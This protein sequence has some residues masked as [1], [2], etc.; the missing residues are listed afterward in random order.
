MSDAISQPSA[1]RR[2]LGRRDL[3]WQFTVR[4]IE[5]KHRGSYLGMLWSVLN[6]LLM[7]GL[8]T[9]MFGVIFGGQFHALPDETKLDYA[10]GLFLGLIFFNVLAETAAMAPILIVTNPNL[11]K[12]VV[13][14]LEILPLSQLGSSVFNF[15]I[16][17]LLLLVGVESFGHGLTA[18]GLLWLPVIAVPHLLLCAG[19][20]LFLAALGVFFRDVQHV[21]Q[22]LT[23]VLL[24]ASA[25]F[26]SPALIRGLP[27]AW[28]ILKWNPLLQTVSLARDALLWHTPV[29]LVALAYTY[30]AGVAVLALGSWF[31]RKMQP[32]FADVL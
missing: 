22:F 20:G 26:F 28:M 31:F 29:N 1:W 4:A 8:Y 15:L 6:P 7:L 14:P 13:F 5:M 27:T 25:I 10:L 30:A 3:W 19:V 24:Y 32:A 2:L 17:F 18:T 23:Q 21:I 9:V 11:V 12:R 16:T